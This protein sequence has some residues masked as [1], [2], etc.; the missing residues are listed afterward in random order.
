[1]TSGESRYI[2]S[3]FLTAAQDKHMY[4]AKPAQKMHNISL[5]CVC[6]QLNNVSLKLMFS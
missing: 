6:R 5:M 3:V 1:M 4:S 2:Y